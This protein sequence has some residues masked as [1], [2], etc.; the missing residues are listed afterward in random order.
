MRS[1]L[2]AKQQFEGVPTAGEEARN[3]DVLEG[4]DG[5]FRHGGVVA[6]DFHYPRF[7]ARGKRRHQ[8]LAPLEQARETGETVP[9]QGEPDVALESQRDGGLRALVDARCR[10]R[11]APGE[12]A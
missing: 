3:R 6:H 12:D 7:L 10:D 8:R 1:W 4:D 11:L 2:L 5:I 9:R